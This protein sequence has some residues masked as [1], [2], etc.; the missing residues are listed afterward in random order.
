MTDIL[1]FHHALGITPGVAAFADELRAAGHTVHVPDLFDGRTF[2]S[3]E[4]GL[5]YADELGFPDGVI[6]RATAAAE[7]LPADLVYLGMSLGVIPAERLAL[8]RPGARGAVFLYSCVPPA[9]LGADA[10]WP[11]G[12]PVQVH[13]MDRDPFFMDE[14]DVDAAREIVAAADRGELFLYP[15]DAHYFADSSQPTYDAGAAA[16]LT[17]R[18][19]AFLASLG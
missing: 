2:D 12:L 10:G 19:L 15:G 3:I 18:V 1:L 8:T 4:A 5:A 7:G 13:G 17:A 14:G 6:G 16:L 9:M 11:A